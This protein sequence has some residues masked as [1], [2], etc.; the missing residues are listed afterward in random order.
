MGKKNLEEGRK[1]EKLHWDRAWEGREV[2][3]V[4]GSGRTHCTRHREDPYSIPSSL[5]FILLK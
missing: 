4:W 5:S 2:L 3:E 1:S